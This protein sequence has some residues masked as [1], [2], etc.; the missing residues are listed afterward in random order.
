MLPEIL[1]NRLEHFSIF[2]AILSC[3]L[4][5]DPLWWVGLLSLGPCLRQGKLRPHKKYKLWSRTWKNKPDV[6]GRLEGLQPGGVIQPQNTEG[7][8]F[9]S[10]TEARAEK[11]GS[12]LSGSSVVEPALGLAWP[13]TWANGSPHPSSAELCWPGGPGEQHRASPTPVQLGR[14]GSRGRRPAES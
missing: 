1:S 6:P 3:R 8:C 4:H 5:T 7:A 2:I 10:G 13:S 14:R 11:S 9:L 12:F